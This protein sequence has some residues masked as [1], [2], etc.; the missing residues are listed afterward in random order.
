MSK[1]SAMEPEV[2]L[3]ILGV[4][5]FIFMCAGALMC[6]FHERKRQKRHDRLLEN[7]THATHPQFSAPRTPW[8]TDASGENSTTATTSPF[9]PF[10][11]SLVPH[12]QSPRVSS[13]GPHIPGSHIPMMM[14]SHG[15][16]TAAGN[17]HVHRPSIPSSRDRTSG[18]RS[19]PLKSPEVLHHRSHLSSERRS[20]VDR[21]DTNHNRIHAPHRSSLERQGE[22]RTSVE[23]H[24]RTHQLRRLS[25][26]KPHAR[27]SLDNQNRVLA[28]LPND[29]GNSQPPDLSPPSS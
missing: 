18:P 3:I 10:R 21:P 20:S 24:N 13:I 9:H 16:P 29:R 15:V 5:V 12:P 27:F 6:F 14:T 19:N 26:E 1:S 7:L 25:A 4:I 17:V 22:H 28:D 8:T 11:L 2:I 23:S